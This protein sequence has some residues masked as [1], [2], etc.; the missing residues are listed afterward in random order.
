L[1]KMSNER[2]PYDGRGDGRRPYDG[3]D[4]GRRPYGGEERD[5]VPQKKFTV[6]I[7]DEDYEGESSNRRRTPA[8][9]SGHG[10]YQP[11]RVR[12]DDRRRREED[13]RI[14]RSDVP[15]SR[16]RVI[17]SRSGDRY[18]I[19][20][21]SNLPPHLM[22]KTN[23]NQKSR[24]CFV[25]VVY[26]AIICSISALLAFYVVVG[27]NDMFGLVKDQME[28][29]VSV[30][31]NADLDTVVKLLDENG[32][33]D[34]PFFFKLY[35][36][37]TNDRDFKR[38][39]FTLNRKSDYDMIIRKLTR[40]ATAD[41]SV[42]TVTIPEGYNIEQIAE[43]LEYNLVCEKEAFYKTIETY[44]FSHSFYSKIPNNNEKRIYR[45]EGYLFPDTYDFYMWE[46]SV[47]AVN[48]M[49]NGFNSRVIENKDVDFWNKANAQKMGMDQIIILASVIERETADPEE[50]KNVASVFYNRL[51]NKSYEG[52]GGKLQ[53]DATRWYPFPTSKAIKESDLTDEQ[54][55][56]WV[57]DY[58]TYNLSGLPP[59]PICCP[60]LNAINAALNPNKTDYFYFY[61]AP[62]KTHYYARTNAEHEVN[63]NSHR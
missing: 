31:D 8:R 58:D 28:I 34:Y 19:S 62:D 17:T 21:E 40:P 13:N 33:V 59:G 32:V 49:L 3:R 41:K 29:V 25:A 14:T 15:I 43:T 57:S 23:R 4:D 12:P 42:V 48:K 37:L 38:G 63:V 56:N 22:K 55:A 18:E 45:L 6:H 53:S 11:Q 54:K 5:M 36:Q 50:M 39:E 9:Q 1:R 35:A 60:G 20:E 47:A 26:A 61:T 27:I 10:A 51:R 44:E 46:G 16:T 30:P 52:I 2:R 7:S 24:G